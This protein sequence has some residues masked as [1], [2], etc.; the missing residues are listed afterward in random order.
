MGMQLRSLF[1]AAVLSLAASLAFATPQIR[2]VT[3]LWQ[4][5]DES[6]WGLNLFHQGDI[7]FGALFVYGS[8]GKPR[9]YV[10]SNLVSNDDGPLHDAATTYTGAAAAIS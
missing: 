1:A 8:D 3:G 9:W 10:A 7:L 5:A 4:N 6:G 2:N